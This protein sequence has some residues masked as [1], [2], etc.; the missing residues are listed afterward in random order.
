VAW[1]Q[2]LR[3]AR[4]AM[5]DDGTGKD[6][7]ERLRAAAH[8]FWRALDFIDSWPLQLREEADAITDTLLARGLVDRTIDGMDDA[9]IREAS[10]QLVAF[11]QRMAELPLQPDEQED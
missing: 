9:Q 7:R 5:D 1:R 3:A 11:C 10:R 2:M 6:G 8:E 4:A